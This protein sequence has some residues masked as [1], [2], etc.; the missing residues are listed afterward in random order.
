MRILVNF[1]Q[2][3]VA[4]WVHCLAAD[5]KTPLSP[6]VE[7]SSEATLRR[8]LRYAGARYT[9]MEEFEDNLRWWGRGSIWIDELTAGGAKLLKLEMRPAAS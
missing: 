4:W 2:R 9:A 3:D 5:C 8:L 6:Y 1:M 7:V